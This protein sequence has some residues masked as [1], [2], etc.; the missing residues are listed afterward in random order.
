MQMS[1]KENPRFRILLKNRVLWQPL[2]LGPAWQEQA[3]ATIVVPVSS[4]SLA[5]LNPSHCHLTHL[6]FL[7]VL[8]NVNLG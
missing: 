6:C 3:M 7:P 4:R 2:G 8:V 1:P 5:L